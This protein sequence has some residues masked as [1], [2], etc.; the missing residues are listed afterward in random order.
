MLWTVTTSRRARLRLAT[1]GFFG[2]ESGI[3]P[4]ARRLLEAFQKAGWQ[5]ELARDMQNIR[6]GSF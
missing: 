3:S 4:R 5:V 1:L 6:P 2:L